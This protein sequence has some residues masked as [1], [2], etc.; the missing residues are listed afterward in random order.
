MTFDA[1]PPQTVTQTTEQELEQAL[2]QLLQLA[3]NHQHAGQNQEAKELYLA[4]LEIQPNH[5]DANHNLGL[6]VWQTEEAAGLAFFERALK[7]QPLEEQYWY[8][9]IDA[10]IQ[11]NQIDTAR[12]VLALGCQHGLQGDRVAQFADL[13]GV[14]VQ[15]STP[16][17]QSALPVEV[18]TAANVAQDDKTQSQ[19]TAPRAAKP[20][21]QKKTSK[22]SHANVPTESEIRQAQMLY[23]QGK[24]EQLE[25][26]ARS[27]TKRMPLHGFGWKVL[28]AVLQGQE[29]F[30]EALVCMKKAVNLLPKDA[31]ALNNLGATLRKAG[32]MSEAEVFVR[33][34]IAIRPNFSEAHNNLGTVLYGQ[35]KFAQA[36]RSLRQAITLKPDY[37]E[38]YSNLGLV[39]KDQGHHQEAEAAL[40]RSLSLK[41]GYFEAL[42]V[43]GILQLEQSRH[44]E[45][46]DSLRRAMAIRED[47]A[48][49]FS[50][51]LYC[52]L[53]APGAEPQQIV[54]DHLAFGER[55][56]APLRAGWQPHHNTKDPERCLQIGF[57]SGDLYHH[58][59]A[60]F[61]EPVLVW[62]AKNP[63]LSLHAYYTHTGEDEVNKR[64]RS[65]FPYWNAVVGL[66][67]A[68]LAD[69]IRTDGID[70]LIDL[71][72]HTANNRLLTFAR[73]AAPL[74]VSWMGYPGTTGLRAMDYFF[75]DRFYTPPGQMDDQFT[76]KLVRL[77]VT[78]PFP[79]SE[80]A[81]A[82]NVL[83]ALRNGYVTFGSF[84]RP[85]KMSRAVIALWAQV[86]RAVPGA[87][88]LLGGMSADEHTAIRDW[89]ES[90]GIAHERLQFHPKMPMDQYLALHHQVDVCLDTFPY[91]GGTTTLHALS[92]G[93][94][95]LSLAGH[96]LAA[97]TGCCVLGQLG[98]NAFVA[99][100]RDDFTRKAM[101][102]ATSLS[103]L[104][105]IRAGLRARLAQ[106]AMGQPDV[107]ATGVALAWRTM[108]KRWCA[109]S[110]AQS[111]EVTMQDV[112]AASP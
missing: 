24:L 107:V 63:N 4:I 71:S 102:W 44:D 64:L 13:L 50:N 82:V 99:D 17:L 48:S 57:V 110:A 84:N 14:P 95:T 91:N 34:A 65:N 37:A 76:E 73:K 15:Q 49:M 97:R 78:A 9:Y 29:R 90:E 58:A 87:H 11:A 10:L 100:D 80:H 112:T 68:K 53:L 51:L 56:E 62:L 70:I 81:P 92:M 20:A 83:P 67:D 22:K 33:R 105:G 31:E 103:E 77:P 21:G 39:L 19:A 1:C 8:S 86:L 35:G 16:V 98:L 54:A 3:A 7:A 75:S 89:F 66:S 6:L 5:A 30:D 52:Q 88:M 12:Q 40:Q 79:V 18:P 85:N 61:L 93:V 47:N 46:A 69:K 109:D 55:F 106:S 111:F 36:Q 72:G 94:P 45:A 25:V 108:W 38:A 104:A 59:V 2:E 41:P 26:F 42:G 74:Q 27:L 32:Q 96:V 28:G 60:S 43:L 23:S 101:H